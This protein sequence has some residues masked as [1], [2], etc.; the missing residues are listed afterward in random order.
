MNLFLVAH[1]TFKELYQSKILIN[2]LFLGG[3]LFLTT[4]IVS[5]FSYGVANK[6]TLDIGLGTLSLSA[7]IIALFLGSGLIQKEISSRTLYMVI[8]RPV[9]RTTFL[10]GKML[11]L[12]GILFVNIII[13]FLMLM[14][15]YFILDGKYN[16]LIPWS[17]FYIY[18]ESLIVM[19][20]VVFF[21]LISN[22]IIAILSTLTMYVAGHAISSV[23][24]TS[25]YHHDAVVKA[26][27]DFYSFVAP[28]FSRF[29]IKSFVLYEKFFDHSILWSSVLYAG[30]WI[31][32]FSIFSIFT[33]SKKEF[34]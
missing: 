31:I 4:Y 23:K 21:S 13:L 14:V 22:N 2:I 9:S 5:E 30:L 20:I 24:D 7:T 34:S 15:F 18:L 33:I 1:Q 11:G 8:S 27:V 19:I 28:D 25:P 12:A 10:M 3:F 32:L 6:V 26:V 16:Y 29:N 17:L